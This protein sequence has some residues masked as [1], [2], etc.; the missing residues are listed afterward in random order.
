MIGREMEIWN[1]NRWF[2]YE[3]TC[4]THAKLKLKQNLKVVQVAK[5]KWG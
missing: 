5:E 1:R 4:I 2:D 3:D